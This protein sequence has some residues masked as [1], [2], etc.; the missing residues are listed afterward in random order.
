LVEEKSKHAGLIQENSFGAAFSHGMP[1]SE[2]HK[3]QQ[4]LKPAVDYLDG[5]IGPAGLQFS[6]LNQPFR[7]PVSS[8]S[9]NFRGDVGKK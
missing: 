5:L 2:C 8:L 4:S 9:F 6:T 3:A 1:L 7:T